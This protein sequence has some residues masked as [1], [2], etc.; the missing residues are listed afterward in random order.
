MYPISPCEDAMALGRLEKQG[1][2]YGEILS[3]LYFKTNWPAGVAEPY[4]L[5]EPNEIF[6]SSNL[7]LTKTHH[8]YLLPLRYIYL[9]QITPQYSCAVMAEWLRRW[10]RNPMGYSLAGSNPA[11]S[12]FYFSMLLPFTSTIELLLFANINA[13]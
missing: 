2:I 4:I 3:F 6:S 9:L 10:T 8:H 7:F 1:Q 5:V 12:V 11:R 13:I